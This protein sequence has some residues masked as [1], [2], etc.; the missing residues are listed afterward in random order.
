MLNSSTFDEEAVVA[1]HSA[2]SIVSV[3][4]N[5]RNRV[6]SLT[7]RIMHCFFLNPSCALPPTHKFADS[8]NRGATGRDAAGVRCGPQFDPS[9]MSTIETAVSDRHRLEIEFVHYAHCRAHV[10]IDL[11]LFRCDFSNTP[12]LAKTK[13]S[14]NT[15]R[16]D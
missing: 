6:S 1:L 10:Q 2:G 8:A 4:N 5:R 13:S 12:G 11:L 7:P 3:A 14:T 15:I 9:I 16:S